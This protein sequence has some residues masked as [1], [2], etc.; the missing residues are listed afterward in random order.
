MKKFQ[1][2]N[3]WIIKK[4]DPNKN[5]KI[6][7]MKLSEVCGIYT[8]CSETNTSPKL[9][10]LNRYRIRLGSSLP[11]Y[12]EIEYHENELEELNNDLK[13][14]QELFFKLN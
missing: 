11:H 10:H 5:W 1:I 6:D 13:D 9:L 4:P 12:F 3:G 8:Y 2:K 7:S 14:L